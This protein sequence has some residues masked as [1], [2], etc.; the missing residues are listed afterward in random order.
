MPMISSRGRKALAG[1]ALLGG[2]L[3]AQQASAACRIQINGFVAQDVTMDMGQIVI[4]PSTPV[5]GV[6]KEISESINQRDRVA[7]CD[8]WSGGR[9]I[10]EYVN[11][12]QKRPVPGFSDTY[13]TDVPGVGIKLFRDSGS[14]QVYYP[15]QLTF[16]GNST[17]TLIG[18]RFRI[19]LIKTAAQTG[20][21]VIAPNGR[22]TTYYF[23]GD[24][25]GRPV[26]TSTFKGSGTTVV[27]PTCEV[28]AGSRNIAVDFGS[29]ANTTFTGVGSKAVDRD[30]EIRLNCQGSNVAAY[31]SKIG[32]RLDADQDSSNMPGVL[33]L[34]AASNSATRIG[35]QMV[36]RDGSTERE[37]RFG[38]TINVGTTAPG[39]SVMA[40]PL[41]ARYV[42]TQA[43]TVGAGVANGQATFTIQYE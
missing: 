9:S 11:A 26:L 37:V 4:L 12:A 35:I 14:I 5:G 24:G 2:V 41:R 13:E 18:G 21:G 7:S 17:V 31:Q 43:G 19:Q 25:P 29:V 38:Q 6:I 34:S 15:H 22:F 42:Q 30:F 28:Q 39:T 40:L 23:D 33:K 8:Y 10:G 27:S 1:L 20:S 32:I 3:L 16:G 36:Q